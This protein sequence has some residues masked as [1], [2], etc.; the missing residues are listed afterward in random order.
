MIGWKQ[1]DHT[2]FCIPPGTEDEAREFYTTVLGF[3]EIAKPES[4][5]SNGGLWLHAGT[6]ELHLGIEDT[7]TPRSKRHSAFEIDDIA[8]ARKRL[9]AHGVDI[10]D[11]T[12]IPGRKRFSFR[13]PFENRIELI[14]F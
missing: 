13:D 5:Q 4:L 12:P 9:E 1:V 10:Q 3:N 7:E 11:E 8:R 6:V 14:E 2:Q